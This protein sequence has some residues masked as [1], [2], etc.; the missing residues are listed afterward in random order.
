MS[1]NYVII[2]NSAAAIGGIEGIRQIDRNGPITVLS[3]ENRH[4]YSRPLI[5]YL[6]QGKTDES[7]MRYRDAD[8][9]QQQNCTVRLGVTVEKIDP[10]AKQVIL[11]GGE[12]VPYGKLLVAAGSRPFVPPLEGL[13]SIDYFTFMTLDSAQALE[14]A[15]SPKS[16]ALIIGGGLI[17]MKCAEGIAERSGAVT[18]AELMPRVLPTVLDEAGSMIIQ[19]QMEAHGVD[20]ILGDSVKTFTPDA[21]KPGEKPRGGTALFN[22]GK[23]AEFD[24]LIAAVGVRPNTQLVSG[25]GGKVEKGI[26]VDEKCRTS[27]PDVF[28]AGDCTESMDISFGQRR[29]LA[30]LPNAYMQGETAGITMAGG[31]KVF[32]TAMPLNAAGFFGLHLVSAGTCAGD[33]VSAPTAESPYRTF[34]IENDMLKGFI[35]IGDTGRSGIY[36]ALIRNRTPLSSIDF[37]SIKTAPALMAF[38]RAERQQMLSGGAK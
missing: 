5:S 35:I 17:G 13:D 37:N 24:V 2:G 8:F 31:E 4:T 21:A 3:S 11:S 32:D 20:F 34:F 10:K 7:R 33:A 26:V 14:K 30:L 28:A 16:R 18:V 27:I 9:Y 25:A 6:L 1:T 29:I 23:T 15:L 19:K 12:Q 38:S 22:S 36:T